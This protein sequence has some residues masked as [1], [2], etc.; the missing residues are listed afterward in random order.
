MED[1]PDVAINPCRPKMAVL[2]IV[3]AMQLEPVAGGVDL[4]IEHARLHS[5]VG[6]GQ[7]SEGSSECVGDQEVHGASAPSRATSAAM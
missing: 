7:S 5:L 4:Q 1:R 3:D 2:A 6:A